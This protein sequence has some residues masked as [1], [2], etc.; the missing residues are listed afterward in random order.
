MVQQKDSCYNYV[1]KERGL[2][3]DYPQFEE[4]ETFYQWIKDVFCH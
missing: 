2:N 3:A 1:N 4:E